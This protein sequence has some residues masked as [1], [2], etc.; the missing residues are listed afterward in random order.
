MEVNDRESSESPNLLCSLHTGLTPRL[1]T[2][3]EAVQFAIPLRYA[4]IME[5]ACNNRLVTILTSTYRYQDAL[6]FL[7]YSLLHQ[8][9]DLLM[10][11]MHLNFSD[12][13][14]LGQ[15]MGVANVIR[16]NL[17]YCFLCHRYSW[18]L[19]RNEY[20]VEENLLMWVVPHRGAEEMHFVEINVTK[21]YHT[22]IESLV[23]TARTGMMVNTHLD[24]GP[25]DQ[26]DGVVLTTNRKAW[27]TPLEC[28]HNII[29]EPIASYMWSLELPQDI[30]HSV[31]T[32]IPSGTL[33]TVPFNA[34]IS[35]G[36]RYA[37]E[38]FG[39]QLAFCATQA[40]FSTVSVE[41]VRERNLQRSVVVQQM[42][43]PVTESNEA[44]VATTAALN[45]FI[46]SWTGAGDTNN[47]ECDCIRSAL[48]AQAILEAIRDEKERQLTAFLI[49]HPHHHTESALNQERES[50]KVRTSDFTE[51]LTTPSE[52]IIEDL[53]S[54]VSLIPRA[55][56]VHF[57][58]KTSYGVSGKEIDGS[59]GSIELATCA[60]DE[61]PAHISSLPASEINRMEL[62]AE[63]V[64]LSN[65]NIG[66]NER[67]ELVEDSIGLARAFLASGTPCV[68]ISQWCTPDIYPAAVF[69]SFYTKMYQYAHPVTVI[70]HHQDT[71]EKEQKN[72][73]NLTSAI[74]E[75]D[76]ASPLNPASSSSIP[77]TEQIPQNGEQDSSTFEMSDRK[78]ED[79]FP[80]SSHTSGDPQH[81]VISTVEKNGNHSCSPCDDSDLHPVS[82]DHTSCHVQ[83]PVADAEHRSEFRDSDRYKANYLARAVRELLE[84]PSM[85]YCP[86]AWAGYYCIGSSFF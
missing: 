18:S 81:P 11:K 13:P 29:L 37:I 36:G 47:E 31:I 30:G 38:D 86:R 69:A 19:E 15:L 79:R 20:D 26:T 33:W 25:T 82:Q 61:T 10:E 35:R 85:R 32:V 67:G 24:G 28:L 2:A 64:S 49:R 46:P 21:E 6:E 14:T 16:S 34:L 27:I 76:A 77:I 60:T 4:S 44:N 63:V 70:R 40:H 65:T 12:S 51:L 59:I 62:F 1:L 78:D 56:T 52:E 42:E 84:D 48:E 7:E 3:C 50:G 22:T 80:S 57:A 5:H 55:R 45:S 39:I 68:V 54:A 23:Q 75:S 71:S 9:Q 66:L 72:G 43:L 83:L 74:R 41:R 8:H 73:G 53:E 17:V 58:T